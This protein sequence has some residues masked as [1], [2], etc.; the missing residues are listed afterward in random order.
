MDVPVKPARVGT[1]PLDAWFAARGWKPAAFQREAWARYRGG[2]SGLL[3][4]P[5]G[6]G[7]TL[8]V[9]GGPLLEGLAAKASRRDPLPKKPAATGHRLRHLWITPLRALA[10]DTAENL[11]TPVADLGLDWRV[12][13]RTGDASARDKRLARGGGFDVLVTTP[14]SLSLLL[15]YA[16]GA[17]QFAGLASVIVDEWHELLGSK[18][19]VLLELALARLRALAPGLRTWGVSATLGNLAQARDTLVPTGDAVLVQGRT[20]R[21]TRVETLLPEPG[22]RFPWAGHLGL[23]QLPRV[24]ATVMRAPTTLLFT[25]TRAQAELWHQALASVWPEEPTTLAL[26]HGSLD[27]ALRS[28]VEDG[29]RAGALRCVVATSSLDLGVDFPTVE[30]VVQVGSPKGIARLLQRAGRARHR[31]N[32]S[33]RIVCVP[34]H[35]LELAEFAAVRASVRD[36]RVEARAPLRL[37]LD[38]LAQHLETIA[39]GSGFDE[40]AMLAEVRTTHAF[41]ELDATHWQAVLD[42]LARGGSALA[43]YPDFRKLERDD[44]GL[45][46]MPDR[47]QALRHRLSIGTILGAGS[48]AVRFLRGGHLG[49]LEEAFVGRLRPGDTFLFAGRSL[50]LVKLHEMTAYVRMATRPAGAVPRWEGGRMPLS[51]QLAQAVE[52]QLATRLAGM[53]ERA[54]AAPLLDLQER[55]SALPRPGA[56]LC[57][58]VRARDGLQLFVYPFAGRTAHEGLATLLAWRWGQRAPATFSTAANDYG[59]VLATD[60]RQALLGEDDI[61]ALLS[62]DDLEEHLAQALNLAEL[63]RRQFREVARVAGMLPP[64]LP[65]RAPRSLRALQASSGLLF[66]VLAKHDPGHVLMGQAEREVWEHLLDTG[67]LRAA[68]ADC[69]RRQLV[70]RHPRRLTPLAFPLWADR[71]RGGLSTEDWRTRVQRA[72]QALERGYA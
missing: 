48:V 50:E 14:E 24:L 53:P 72:A 39:L 17:L 38:V 55:A 23:S 51:T 7:K 68:L 69:A 30:Q 33:S 32:E 12:G 25:N 2:H 47:R 59:F 63:A 21:A 19:G 52:T 45:W 29:L 27:P 13:L 49:Q 64:S 16:D 40:T 31:P 1:A 66:D 54:A 58:L 28:A 71:S 62:P 57:E 15:S 11:R 6:S 22:E 37:S 56:L 46:R 36:G 8:A 20:P 44:T 61:A 9:F 10:R 4:A 60:A 41:A 18:R 34:T 35:L 42:Y 26:H 67:H 3:H 43:A 5:T 65:G 70:L